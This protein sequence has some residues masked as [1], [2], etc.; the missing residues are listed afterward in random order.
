MARR[1]AW[2]AELAA[3]DDD[4][5]QRAYLALPLWLRERAPFAWLRWR[6]ASLRNPEPPAAWERLRYLSPRTANS[7]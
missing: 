5:L 3:M 1:A 6:R 4:E 2:D 7:K